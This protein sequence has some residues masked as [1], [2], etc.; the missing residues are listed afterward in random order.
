MSLSTLILLLHVLS[1]A[2]TPAGDHAAVRDVIIS[3]MN[4][5][6][7]APAQFLALVE[8]DAAWCDP[9]P[10]CVH[11]TA[12]ISAFLKSMPPGTSTV[13]LAESMVTVGSVGGMMTTI[14]FSWPGAAESC[15]YTADARVMELESPPHSRPGTKHRNHCY[16][17]QG[18]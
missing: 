9:Y 7:S 11:G 18:G 6:A 3:A 1:S 8:D 12:N 17:Q 2:A 10:S 4:D 16:P 14:S 15:L 5:F 13:L